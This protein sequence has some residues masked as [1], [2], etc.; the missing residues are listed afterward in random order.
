MSISRWHNY[1][2]ESVGVWKGLRGWRVVVVEESGDVSFTLWILTH[3]ITF[4]PLTELKS[5]LRCFTPSRLLLSSPCAFK[6]AATGNHVGVSIRWQEAPTPYPAGFQPRLLLA[7]L[8]PCTKGNVQN[9]PCTCLVVFFF[10]PI[11]VQWLLFR[12]RVAVVRNAS[13]FRRHENSCIKFLS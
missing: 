13:F 1:Q 9:S 3:H 4:I 12:L 8:S 2:E 7:T 5:C 6:M 10:L 11:H